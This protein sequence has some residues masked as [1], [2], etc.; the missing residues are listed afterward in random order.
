MEECFQ[1]IG[2]VSSFKKKSLSFFPS[3]FLLL[4]LFV[5]FLESDGRF[6]VTELVVC[7][8]GIRKSGY[9]QQPSSE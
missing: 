8:G 2:D 6:L 5:S 1:E 9:V 4:F 7:V 3:I